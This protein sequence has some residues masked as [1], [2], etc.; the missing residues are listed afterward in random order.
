MDG[1]L[2]SRAVDYKWNHDDPAV[3][4]SKISSGKHKLLSAF[5]PLSASKF[6]LLLVTMRRRVYNVDAGKKVNVKGSRC[7]AGKKRKKRKERRKREKEEEVECGGRGEFGVLR[8]P[9]GN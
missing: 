4:S 6:R 1:K 3:G 9:M 7:F 2:S 8:W 5:S